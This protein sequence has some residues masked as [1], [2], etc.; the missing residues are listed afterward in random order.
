[1]T[2]SMVDDLKNDYLLSSRRRHRYCFHQSPEVDLHDIVICY[3]KTSY[4][5]PNKHIGKSES[6]LI[7]QG[8][9]DF[10]I[11]DDRGELIDLIELGSF[12]TGKTCYL[13]IPANTWHGLRA[14]SNE[15]VIMKE[16]ISGPYDNSSLLWADFAPVESAENSEGHLWYSALEDQAVKF[17]KRAISAAE[18]L[19]LTG[20][21][22]YVSSS[23][24]ARF[25]GSVLPRLI[26]AARKSNLK[27]A[28]YCCHSSSEEKMQEMFIL[29][30]RE[31]DIDESYHIRKD[32]SL[33]VLEGNGRYIFP[34]EDG[35][36]RF[37]LPLSSF[38]NASNNEA[39]FARINR[40][41]PHKISV[42]S[43]YLLI[44]EST[45]GPFVKSDTDYRI[46]TV[47]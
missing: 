45:T 18:F 34:N 35:G 2:R 14:T 24:I 23:T 25:D 15:P 17:R 31:T 46:K 19:H 40:Y 21:S 16:T 39:F 13:R 26:E 36:E 3:D 41:V 38:E 37:N 10:Y 30:L 22:V 42:E 7:L 12:A 28:R 32:E 5:R 44:Y 9:L 33:L 20:P 1:M 4:I 29:L 8:E 11:F 27:R 47:G 43:E 6:L